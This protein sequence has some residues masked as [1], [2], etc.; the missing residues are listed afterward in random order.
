MSGGF[1]KPSRR[2]EVSVEPLRMVDEGTGGAASDRRVIRTRPA[3]SNTAQRVELESLRP[4]TACEYT[5]DNF[6]G[7]RSRSVSW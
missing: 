2:A 1:L 6:P 5:P 4:G 3:R 7:G